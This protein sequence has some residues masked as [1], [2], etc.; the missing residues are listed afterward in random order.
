[1]GGAL[2]DSQR[3]AALNPQGVMARVGTMPVGAR[4]IGAGASRSF[5]SVGT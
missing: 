2:P 5:S 4:T 1:M 3:V